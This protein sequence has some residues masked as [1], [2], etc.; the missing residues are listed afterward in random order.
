MAMHLDRNTETAKAQQ[1]LVRL[2]E[3]IF[4]ANHLV[5][6]RAVTFIDQHLLGIVGPA[7]DKSVTAENLFHFRGRRSFQMKELQVMARKRLVNRDDVGRVIVE[8]RKPFLLLLLRP[9]LFHR[10]DVIKR[11]GRDG[12]ER[13]RG[14]HR[15]KARRPGVGRRLLNFRPKFRRH[16]DD[17]MIDQKLPN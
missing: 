1:G 7:L 10:G 5:A 14:I 11:F 12:L 13:A 16:G 6:L 8:G 3:P 4:G 2:S 15:G 9:F 17:M